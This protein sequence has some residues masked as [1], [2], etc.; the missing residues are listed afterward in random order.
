MK[1]NIKSRWDSTVLF[2]A[3]AAS[4]LLALQVAVKS[5][6][7]LGGANLRSADLGG[8][9]LG[10]ANLRSANLGGANLY[11]ADL[12]GAD[13]YGADLYGANLRSA[14]LNIKIGR[15]D[16][17]GWSVLVTPDKTIIG[18]QEHANKDWLKHTPKSVASMHPDAAKW[19]KQHGAVVKALIRDVSSK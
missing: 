15:L 1:I 10:G 4:L 18:C 13:L 17:G 8:A 6:A 2:T 5:G 11:G 7:N 12:G 14:N 19:W 3:E 16:F 9:N